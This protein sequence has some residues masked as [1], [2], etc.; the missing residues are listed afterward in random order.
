MVQQTPYVPGNVVQQVSDHKPQGNT[1][2]IVKITFDDIKDEIRYWD[3]VVVCY[4]LG[5]NPPLHVIDGFVRRIWKDLDIE[6]VGMVRKGVFIVK[7][8]DTIARDI[9]CELSGILFDKRPF[10]IKPWKVKMSLE[11]ENLSS[12]PIWVQLSALAMEYWDEKCIRKI[13]GLLGDV[14]KV[15]NDTKNKERLMYTRALV[16]VDTKNGLPEEV[17]FTNEYD[18]LVKQLVHYDLETHLV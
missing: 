17:F 18:E 14:I 15:D 9:A 1:S 10:I 4:V 16:E 7:L 12:I 2:N 13:A 6:K 5:V 11:K 3:T 8:N